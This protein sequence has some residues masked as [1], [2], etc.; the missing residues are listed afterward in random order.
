MYIYIYINLNVLQV[1]QNDTASGKE[2]D[3]N[4]V[5]DPD[6]PM[7]YICI[8]IYINLNVLQLIQN[9]TASGKEND[10]NDSVTRRE[11]Y[12]DIYL[13]IHVI[14]LNVLQLIQTDTASDKGMDVNDVK[15]S[16]R[17]MTIS[18]IYTYI[19]QNDLH[20]L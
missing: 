4:Y 1:M 10:V 14:F 20:L 13:C 2:N 12:Y 3:V 8:Y 11:Y 18:Y 17:P 6:Q 19:N 9:D 7:I 5:R 16:D 15:D